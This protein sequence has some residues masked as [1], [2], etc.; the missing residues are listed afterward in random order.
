MIC[1]MMDQH[2]LM[3][4][5]LRAAGGHPVEPYLPEGYNGRRADILFA[6]PP[7]VVEVKSIGS[8]RAASTEVADALGVMFAKNITNGAPVITEKTTIHLYV[9]PEVIAHKAMRIIGKRVQRESVDANKQIKAT[10]AALGLEDPYGLLVFITPPFRLDR[11]SIVWL[12]NDAVKGGTCRSINGI[13]VVETP[14][15]TSGALPSASNAFI[16]FHSRDGRKFPP[17]LREAIGV[18]WGTVTGQRMHRADEEDFAKLGA[19]S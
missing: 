3:V 10:I 16:S 7:V 4:D 8:D 6:D 9:L 15:G 17:A 19:T 18:A 5:V 11:R 2:E 12:V 13:L 14:L 1:L